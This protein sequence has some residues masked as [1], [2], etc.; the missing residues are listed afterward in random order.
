LS[1]NNNEAYNV[2]SNKKMLKL[3]T[4]LINIPPCHTYNYGLN[5]IRYLCCC[6]QTA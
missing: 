2:A 6:K 5:V 3:F 4:M 1:G